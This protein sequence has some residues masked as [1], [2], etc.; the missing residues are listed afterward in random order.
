MK[1][2]ALTALIAAS[3][4]TGSVMAAE[5]FKDRG[6]DYRT[7]AQ[8]DTSLQREVVTAQTDRFKN[9]GIDYRD[10]VSV[11]A[12]TPRTEVDPMIRGFNDRSH[13]A[14]TTERQ[15]LSGDKRLGYKR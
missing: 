10:A 11:S 9:G 13:I 14:F 8:S 4:S 6:I 12:N 2:I 5:S 3:L 1:N 15:S 7:T